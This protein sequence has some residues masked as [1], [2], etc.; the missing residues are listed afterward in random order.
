[1]KPT[2]LIFVGLISAV[3]ILSCKKDKVENI[4]CDGSNPTYTG[5]IRAIINANCTSNNCHPNYSTYSGLE[6][7]LQNGS[8][9]REVLIDQTMPRN[10]NLSASELS[11]IKCWVE[12]DFPEN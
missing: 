1:M 8:F 5:Q 10:G 11:K 9:E 6:G 4:Q 2:N 3:L 12:N 7:A